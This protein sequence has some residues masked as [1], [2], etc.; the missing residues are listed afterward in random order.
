M[1]GQGR[2]D[3]AEAA[4]YDARELAKLCHLSVRQLER[5][6]R[7]RQSDFGAPIH[8]EYRQ[9]SVFPFKLMKTSY[10]AVVLSV[11]AFFG[12][13]AQEARHNAGAV[14]RPEPVTASQDSA[15]AV[16]ERGPHHRVWERT[17]SDIA[18]DGRAISQ[19]HR[20]IELATGMH[21]WQNGQ[22]VESQ[23]LIESFPGGAIARQGQHQ[24]IF[25]NNLATVGAIDMQTPDGKRMRSH[26]LGLSYFDT[27]SGQSVL[28]AEVKDSQGQLYPPNVV[29]YPDAFTD[30]KAD[31]RYTYTRAGF[32]QDII[33]HERPPGPE[34]YGLDPATTRL[35]VLTE[36]LNP[37]Q[38]VKKQT[39][40]K[41][42]QGDILDEDLDFGMMKMGR[43]KAFLL[44][45][46]GRDIPVSKQWLKLEGREFLVEEV[47]V[48]D[49]EE[50]LQALPAAEGAS[51]NS[52]AGS[53]RHV[54]SKQRLLPAMLLV[55][56]GTKQMHLAGLSLP[57]QGLVLD[58]QILNSGSATNYTF[59]GDTTYYISGPVYLHGTTTFEGGAVLKYG[60]GSGGAG[61]LD[62]YGPNYAPLNVNWQATAYRPVIFTSMGDNSVGETISGSRGNPGTYSGPAL[63]FEQS[64]STTLANFRIAY[65][66]EAI[67]WANCSGNLSIY[68]AQFVNC[69]IGISGGPGSVNLRNVLFAN[70]VSNFYCGT[71][72]NINAQNVTFSGSASGGNCLC[73]ALTGV[74]TCTLT[75]CILAN[76][77]NLTKGGSFTLN[78]GYNGFYNSPT[79]GTSQF[80]NT[81]YPFQ[82]VG[83]GNYY[84]TDG[85][86]F[87]N[88]GANNIDSTLLA[89]LKTRT[90]YPPMVYSNTV[91]S[92][93]YFPP[94]AQRDTNAAP[95]LGYH[96]DP[97]DYVFGG[98]DGY[99][100]DSS[101]YFAPG[102]AAGWFGSVG[103]VG[104]QP[105]GYSL[106]NGALVTFSG[107]ATAPCVF[108]CY[109]T[110]QEGGNT[111]WVQTN[112]LGGILFNGDNSSGYPPVLDAQFT[113]WYELSSAS[114]HV[115]DNG[116]F[117]VANV[118]H[119]EF[120]NGMLYST[121]SAYRF[122]NNL[123][124]RVNVKL[125]SSTDGASCVFQNCTFWNG[126][127]T[128]ARFSGQDP[129]S[130]TILNSAFDGITNVINDGLGGNSDYTTINCNAFRTNADW[131]SGSHDVSV[132]NFNW[133]TNW[134][135][136]FY[137]PPDSRL[138]DKGSTTADQV[139]LYHFTTQTNQVKE[140]NSIVDI[141]YH[142][143]AVTTDGNPIDTDGD[144]IPDN[145]EDSNGNGIYDDWSDWSDW[146]DYYNGTLPSLTIVDGDKQSGPFNAFLPTPLLLQASDYWFGFPLTNAPLTFSVTNGLN[147]L[148]TSLGGTLSSN[149]FL[150]TDAN[151]NAEVYLFL[152]ANAPATNVVVV[153]AGT[154]GTTNEVDFT[155]M[156][157][158]V[159]VPE[160]SPASGTYTTIQ[161]VTIDC[162]TPG[163]VI[164]YTL[165]G[166]DP[167]EAA[168]IAANGQS[169]VISRTTT[170]KAAAFEDDI[171]LP[172]DV[173]EAD[174]T[175][176]HPLMAGRK[177]TLVLNTDGT[178]LAGGSGG[179][180]Q[181]GDGTTHLRTN[182]VSVAGAS[183]VVGIAAGELFSYAWK[184]NGTAWALAWGDDRSGEMGNG[185]TTHRQTNAIPI[186]NLTA[187][188]GMSAGNRHGLAVDTNG[189]VWAWGAND[190]GQLG[191]NIMVYNRLNPMP[192]ANLAGAVAVAAGS[193]HSLALKTNG[194]VW[195][196]GSAKQG[197]LGDGTTPP[198]RT[199]PVQAAGLTNISAIA[200]GKDFSLAISNGVVW[201]W[202][203]IE[204]P[205]PYNGLLFQSST[206]TKVTIIRLGGPPL[207]NIVAIAA[208][209]YHV[210]ALKSD[211][212]VWSW[213]Y[214]GHCQLGKG[215][216]ASWACQ[217]IGL[218]NVVAIA[219]GGEHSAALKSDGTIAL[220]GYLNYGQELYDSERPTTPEPLVRVF[221]V[222]DS[223]GNGLPDWWEF[224]YF[225]RLGMDPNSDPNGD[226]HSL[227]YDYT[228]GLDPNV[229]QFELSATNLY[230]NTLSVPLQINLAGGIPNYMAVLVNDT[231]LADANWRAYTGT[232][233]TVNVGP[234]DGVYS[235][236]VG[237]RN[238]SADAPVWD[239][240]DIRLHLD[241]VPPG[242]TITNPVL[243]G[244]AGT[245]IKP[246]LQLQGFANEPLLGVA[247]DL[248]NALGTVSNVDGFVTDQVFDSKL[249]D[250]TTNYFQC[251]DIP[252]TNGLNQI[253]LRV[254]DRAG[255]MT[256]TNIAVTLD[257]TL[258]TVPPVMNL[259]WP[260]DGMQISGGNFTLRG[261]LNDETAGVVAQIVDANNNTNIVTGIVERNGMFWVEN[262]PLTNG[263]NI[264]TVTATDAAGNVST[265]NITVSESA[266]ALTINSTPTG[267][268]LYKPSGTVGG[269][270]SDPG[271]TVWV[272]GVQANTNYNAGNGVWYW[273]A[274]NVPIYG[275]GTM[276]FDA[277]AFP[278]EQSSFANVKERGVRAMSSSSAGP[279]A[280]NASAPVEAGPY[281]AITSHNTSKTDNTADSDG[282]WS[283]FTGTK[284]YSADYWP[285][286]NGNWVGVYQ[287]T[288]TASFANN[289][290]WSELDYDWSDT[291][292]DTYYADNHGS[293]SYP[294]IV[295][296]Y[297]AAYITCVP[298]TDLSVPGSVAYPA[299]YPP[300]FVY[301]YR[302]DGVAWHWDYDYGNTT[303]TE[304]VTVGA[305]TKATLYTGGK[306]LRMGVFCILP[307]ATE[308]GKPPHGGWASTPAEGIPATSL[309]VVG[310][311]PGADG[312]V[313]KS[314]PNGDPVD[315][316]VTAPAPHYDAGVEVAKYTPVINLN[317]TT[318]EPDKSVVTACVGQ[319]LN[320]TLEGLPSFEDATGKWNLPGK[321]VNEPYQYSSSCTSYRVNSTLLDITGQNLATACWYVN[322]VDDGT[323]GVNANLRFSN[324]QT[325][326]VAAKGIFTIYRPKLLN[327]NPNPF[328]GVVLHW[329]SPG[330]SG[331]GDILTI[332]PDID[333][334]VDVDSLF[335]GG[336]F[337]TQTLNGNFGNEWCSFDTKGLVFLDNWE[338]VYGI[339]VTPGSTKNTIE[340]YDKPQCP[341]YHYTKEQ[342][343]FTDYIRFQPDGGIPVTL[344]TVSWHMNEDTQLATVPGTTNQD[345][346][347]F[348]TASELGPDGAYHSPAG[349]CD[350]NGGV[351]GVDTFPFWSN[352]YT[353]GQCN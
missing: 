41:K 326:S 160:I 296:D 107:T 229:I 46:G 23:E 108:A 4:H 347:P 325:A 245:V 8:F 110:V 111:N 93:G 89:S 255:N 135:G 352:V 169:F 336:A 274:N 268:A 264:L 76:V 261:T 197:E 331:W 20:Y 183:N 322:K 94:Q 194:T 239:A 98:V 203:A 189:L 299:G 237:L 227:L 253:T 40:L 159:A 147:Q 343:R 42:R 77:T 207:T 53:A 283:T 148:A 24:V 157:G 48:P 137:L 142:Y 133:Q 28:I 339:T 200:A 143:V 188:I 303:A 59:Q 248:T 2:A 281:V 50:E 52:A 236:W 205:Y 176:V 54:V 346:I 259:I 323:V 161:N 153:T 165:D 121:W 270:I 263:D 101:V 26:V 78:G 175:I 5:D 154:E 33:L 13:Q 286:S 242:L 231:N 251:Y 186:T 314:I 201:Q 315:I 73:V 152:P 204:Q 280:A 258:A 180:G 316:T 45:Q 96:Y 275:R 136:N 62:P 260:Q 18:P 187:V 139:G 341:C 150:R 289:N 112:S 312:L 162:A 266:I 335:G 279:A 95:D 134:L 47:A 27:A 333:Y 103:N 174:I 226:G 308:Y 116:A 210:L 25:A 71:T 69:G 319:Y 99:S 305:A 196:W 109:N 167:T 269:S 171:F 243:S 301:H 257:Y 313:W 83:G 79:L 334:T 182:L 353:N 90:T 114:D 105:Y 9:P 81:F 256:T 235:V 141:G 115:R 145:L 285:D 211:G 129:A 307:G 36:F 63:F 67:E 348:P 31:V 97:L 102:T 164:H 349:D 43:G 123:L 225:G 60:S 337:I 70:V 61:I 156:V 295:P 287:G 202:G 149:L 213:G 130:W 11:A 146:Q 168:P 85:C 195:G 234:T 106:N 284:N 318:L 276:T 198:L 158:R 271:Y 321:Y 292:D 249:V 131:T 6:F 55:Q 66:Q 247:Y 217:V 340:F 317:G 64:S 252:L 206:P 155:C 208:G 117:G 80:T 21:Y 72:M 124:Q 212:T 132:T 192:V 190:H 223:D 92:D 84:L 87:H 254:W 272:N 29:I 118:R 127:L 22:W 51:L 332:D 75:N 166:S 324:G 7:H 74:Q 1:T 199:I 329:H 10:L 100:D 224:K 265:T 138:I 163:A 128:L 338:N 288:S 228:N 140:T 267:D 320:F 16:V 58:Y 49:L 351:V 291:G 219:A 306:A 177:H 19:V 233:I 179:N 65:A 38:P 144:G 17:T 327:F 238:F 241:R 273:Q 230:V 216:W 170:M 88:V 191:T 246:Y 294:D 240:G 209:W 86:G 14:R 15:Y 151:G 125:D 221:Y 215:S 12:T 330:E 119:C 277:E 181:I 35:Q 344:G 232:N 120:Y 39:F 293:W 350:Y 37:P 300:T 302:A 57:S 122:T 262:L 193:Y 222:L 82:S 68:N 3:L 250:F 244:A 345:Y 30:F 126:S 278:M 172:S 297:D 304:D 328:N 290:G 184:S 91:I 214:D 32:E 104:S 311:H 298:D 342:Q 220:W 34:A 56:T 113:K 309:T 44:E 282:N 185:T 173:A 178:I 218:S 310:K